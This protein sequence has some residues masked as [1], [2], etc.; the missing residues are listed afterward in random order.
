[1]A[2]AAD[3]AE[4]II[5]MDYTVKGDLDANMAPIYESLHGG[6]TITLRDIKVK[7]LKMF[8]AISEKT[9]QEY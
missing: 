3:K 9:G 2:T 4:G 5:S 6:G 7:G 1:M 8:G